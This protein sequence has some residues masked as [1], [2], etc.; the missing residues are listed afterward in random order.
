MLRLVEAFDHPGIVAFGPLFWGPM[1]ELYGRAR[2]L[3]T[4]NFFFL[5]FNTACGLSHNTGEFL[6]FRLLAGFGGSAPLSVCAILSTGI[7]DLDIPQ[8]R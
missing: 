3:Q 1:S 5:I 6:A 2:I 4:A 7:F 8:Y